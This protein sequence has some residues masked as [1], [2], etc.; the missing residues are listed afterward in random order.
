MCLA[1]DVQYVS[2]KHYHGHRIISHCPRASVS[3]HCYGF[4]KEGVYRHVDFCPPCRRKNEQKRSLGG[5][6]GDSDVRLAERLINGAVV[7]ATGKSLT[8][9]VADRSSAG[10]GSGESRTRQS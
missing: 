6:P 3:Q 2:C 10:T 1:E 8:K 4:K 5:G 7:R 9:D